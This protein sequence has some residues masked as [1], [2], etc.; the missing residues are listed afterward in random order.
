[1]LIAFSLACLIFGIYGYIQAIPNLTHHQSY[2]NSQI[3]QIKFLSHDDAWE[4]MKGTKFKYF[5]GFQ[6]DFSSIAE[7]D[8]IND[9]ALCFVSFNLGEVELKKIAALK[10]L[11]TIDLRYSKFT[12]PE[13]LRILGDREVWIFNDQNIVEYFSGN[14][15]VFDHTPISFEVDGV[16]LS[17]DIPRYPPP[18]PKA[19]PPKQS[20][21][22][23]DEIK[24]SSEGWD[25]SWNETMKA[26][27]KL[28]P[29]SKNKTD[30]S[31]I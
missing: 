19:K 22:A 1:M 8:Y 23:N 2:E 16:K 28:A 7:D 13:A 29:P 27:E 30:K 12:N 5:Y 21:E 20:S 11:K 9:K 31:T 14:V 15:M 26:L 17:Q 6:N 3:G 24:A 18:P 25:E 4:V 10:N